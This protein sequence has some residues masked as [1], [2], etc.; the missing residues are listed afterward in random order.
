MRKLMVIAALVLIG[1]LAYTA[2]LTDYE[3]IAIA[4]PLITQIYTNPEISKNE[5]L[6]LQ[7][8]TQIALYEKFSDDICQ[9]LKGK[10]MNKIG[11]TCFNEIQ[12]KLNQTDWNDFNRLFTGKDAVDKDIAVMFGNKLGVDAVLDSYLMF[13]YYN[14]SNGKRHLE[15]HFEWYL[16]DLVSGEAT[17]AGKYDYSDEFKEDTDILQN[18]MKCV[19]SI[20]K[21][22]AD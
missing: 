12:S 15:A 9:A 10:Y 8:E 11:I 3:T 17:V 21:A 5:D 1:G 13:S 14:N 6:E 7:P 19:N 16:I 18:E 2:E 22:M 4:S 20:V